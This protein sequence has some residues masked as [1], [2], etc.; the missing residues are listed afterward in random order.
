MEKLNTRARE[1][2]IKLDTTL[3][4]LLSEISANTEPVHHQKYL[5]NQILTSFIDQTPA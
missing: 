5:E 4:A 3:V 1:R 2:R